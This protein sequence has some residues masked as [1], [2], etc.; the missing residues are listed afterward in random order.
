M[1]DSQVG[2]RLLINARGHFQYANDG[3]LIAE[4]LIM[5]IF[6]ENIV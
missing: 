1:K 6:K 5:V 2:T 3:K 4:F